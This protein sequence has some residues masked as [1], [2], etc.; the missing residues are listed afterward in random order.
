[1]PSFHMS[2]GCCCSLP[3]TPVHALYHSPASDVCAR[4][5]AWLEISASTLRPHSSEESPA[6]FMKVYHLF[7]PSYPGTFDS[8]HRM[9]TLTYPVCAE[10]FLL[11]TSNSKS[12]KNYV[13]W[14]LPMCL[15]II[16]L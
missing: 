14:W 7:G 10:V 8:R 4:S 5:D 12:H 16:T 11:C 3:L 15:S 2:L 9:Y 13:S 6:T 1:M